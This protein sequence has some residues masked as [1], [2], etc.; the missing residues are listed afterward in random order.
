MVANKEVFCLRPVAREYVSLNISLDTREQE[1][2]LQDWVCPDLSDLPPI[3]HSHSFHMSRRT[4][5]A[6][7]AVRRQRTWEMC[8]ISQS[9]TRPMDSRSYHHLSTPARLAAAGAANQ[10]TTTNHR[11][12][13]G[14]GVGVVHR[15]QHTKRRW[16]TQARR[17]DHDL[18]D[19]HH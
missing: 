19:T 9:R 6:Q 1:V 13:G 4:N 14:I 5:S 8:S 18:S 12:R 10:M 7:Q 17:C 16:E 3:F 15:F 2:V 11:T